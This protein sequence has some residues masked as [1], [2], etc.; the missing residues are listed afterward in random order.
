MG[1]PS[2]KAIAGLRIQGC[3]GYKHT[4]IWLNPETPELCRKQKFGSYRKCLPMMFVDCG[5]RSP[6]CWQESA[7]KVKEKT[8]P[9][10]RWFATH[11]VPPCASTITLAI[12]NPMPLPFTTS[13]WRLPR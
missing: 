13:R 8:Q 2:F 1:R 3:P 4:L 11:R 9:R 12:D 7:G 6:I 5:T 10:P